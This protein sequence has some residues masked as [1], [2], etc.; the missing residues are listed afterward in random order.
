LIGEVPL[1]GHYIVA[2]PRQFVAGINKSS[3]G[4]RNND[5]PNSVDIKNF[6]GTLTERRGDGD[7]GGIQPNFP[8]SIGAAIDSDTTDLLLTQHL[9]IN[10]DVAK[11]QAEE[12]W[13]ERAIRE[14]ISVRSL[15]TS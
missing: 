7:G 13:L 6:H 14:R 10:D 12:K 11:L 9:P 1:F 2:E 5:K 3:T 4:R 8:D 15:L